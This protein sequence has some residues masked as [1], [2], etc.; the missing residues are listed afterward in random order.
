MKLD[1]IQR[2]LK[3]TLS[4]EGVFKEGMSDRHHPWERIKYGRDMKCKSYKDMRYFL[5]VI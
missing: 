4:A 3:S 2:A 5:Q 1:M